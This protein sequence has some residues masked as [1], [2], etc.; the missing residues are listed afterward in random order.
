MAKPWHSSL[1]RRGSR[2]GVL[3]AGDSRRV[4]RSAVIDCTNPRRRPGPLLA[5]S[6]T[7]RRPDGVARC[8]WSLGQ[9]CRVGRAWRQFRTQSAGQGSAD[10]HRGAQRVRFDR[11]VR[12]LPT[13]WAPGAASC[14]RR[15]RAEPDDL[16]R[17]AS[18]GD[19]RQDHAR[20]EPADRWFLR[21]RPPPRRPRCRTQRAGFGQAGAL[22]EARRCRGCGSDCRDGRP[23]RGGPHRRSTSSWGWRCCTPT[24]PPAQQ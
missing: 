13:R 8:S 21:R 10:R 23:C 2:P 9:L 11:R 16:R 5:R 24:S 20:V 7:L 15:R 3:R 19:V 18:R 1:S 17:H 14:G 4:Q 12:W 22:V 6:G